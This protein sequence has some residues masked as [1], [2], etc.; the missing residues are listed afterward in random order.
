MAVVVYLLDPYLHLLEHGVI[1]DAREQYSH[2]VGP[3]LK[4]GDA[5]SVQLLG[6]LMD[7]CLQLCKGWVEGEK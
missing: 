3:V 1:L 6:Q 4:E 7:V 5:R 2:G